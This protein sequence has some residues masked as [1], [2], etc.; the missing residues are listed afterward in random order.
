VITGIR[1]LDMDEQAR[2]DVA[3]EFQEAIVDTLVGKSLRA[4]EQ[5]GI[6]RLVV[7]GGV[8]ANRVLRARLK[9]AAEAAGAEVFYPGWSSARIMA[10]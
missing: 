9:E 3:R 6:R 10:R 2:A 8:G 7:A 1:D 4:V 5:T